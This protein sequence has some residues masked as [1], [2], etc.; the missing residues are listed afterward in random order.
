MVEPGL[1]L[2]RLPSAQ[3][4][5]EAAGG[6][7]APLAARGKSPACGRWGWGPAMDSLDANAAEKKEREH[8]QQQG[9]IA[10]GHSTGRKAKA[11]IF[12]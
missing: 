6:R 10:R 8:R 12:S 2:R 4:L 7:G 5:K 11:G 1:E 9:W 3:E